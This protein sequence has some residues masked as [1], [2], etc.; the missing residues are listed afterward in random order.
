MSEKTIL[1]YLQEKYPDSSKT[2]LKSWVT[3]GRVFLH[4]KAIKDPRLLVDSQDNIRLGP[5][6]HYTEEGI[7]VLYQDPYI[8]VVYKPAGILSVPTETDLLENAY[9]YLKRKFKTRTLYPVHRIDREVSGVMV[10]AFTEEV[11]EQLQEQFE[12]HSI[13]RE[14]VAVVEGTVEPAKGTW[15]SYLMEEGVYYVRSVKEESRGKLATTHYEVIAQTKGT[16][17]LRVT[18]ETGRKN[19]IRVHSSEAGYPILGDAKYRSEQPFHGR[20]ALQACKLGLVHP[21]SKKSLVFT[22]ALDPE[23]AP[24][25]T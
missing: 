8:L 12:E 25:I 17:T 20:V 10:F 5:K 11:Q 2:T 14:Y 6:R 3:E 13:L 23:F 15:Q 9:E 19:Q 18:L 24:Y 16:S 21:K 7:E 1:Q 4:D 22:K